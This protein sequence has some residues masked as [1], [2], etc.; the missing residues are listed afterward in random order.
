VWLLMTLAVGGAAALATCTY[1]ERPTTRY[2]TLDDARAAG[3]LEPGKWLPPFMP[4]SSTSI[5]ETHDVDT[6]AQEI[7]F[8]YTPGDTGAVRAACTPAGVEGQF[9]CVHGGSRLLMELR[10]DGGGRITSQP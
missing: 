1:I 3:A 6:N 5:V 8:R 4:A 7:S 9:N 2:A 10:S